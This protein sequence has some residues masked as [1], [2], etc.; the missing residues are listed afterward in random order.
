M[1]DHVKTSRWYFEA[2]GGVKVAD[3]NALKSSIESHAH[4]TLAPG[5]QMDFQSTFSLGSS[6]RRA[7]GEAA[8]R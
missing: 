6:A 5:E 3:V 1:N 7:R 2:D 8:N 4:G